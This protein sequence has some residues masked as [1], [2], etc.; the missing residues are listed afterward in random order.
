VDLIVIGTI[1]FGDRA[2]AVATSDQ[3]NAND[4][5]YEWNVTVNH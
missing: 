1:D 3:H 4:P 2:A 5:S